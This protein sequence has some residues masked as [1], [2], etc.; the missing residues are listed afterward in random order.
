M[1]IVENRI[2]HEISV[3]ADPTTV[4]DYFTDPA[5]LVRWQG[6][7]ANLDARPG[8]RYEV[9]L[10]DRST[11]VG[12]YREVERPSRVVFTWG[13][14]GNEEIPEGSSLVEVTLAADGGGT[15]VR[16]V[17]NGLPVGELES[18]DD[19]WNRY[20]VRLVDVAAGREAGPDPFADS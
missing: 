12:E 10:N 14:V 9:E 15:R 5:L 17:H 6:R 3:E 16:L 2:E 4:F 13:W 11:S 19:G 18:H 1:P 7:S 20:L 8:G